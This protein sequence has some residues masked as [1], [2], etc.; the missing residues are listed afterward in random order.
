MPAADKDNAYVHASTCLYRL[1][2]KVSAC[3]IGGTQ[4][5]QRH[6]LELRMCELPDSAALPASSMT[7]GGPDM[8]TT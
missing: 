2:Y 6:V 5:L 3:N 1:K 7:C 8:F 4:S